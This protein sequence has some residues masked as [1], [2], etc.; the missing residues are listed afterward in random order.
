MCVA[1]N[2]H[3]ISCRAAVGDTPRGL[4]ERA[5]LPGDEGRSRMKPWVPLGRAPIPGT[6]RHGKPDEL[7]LWRRG[8]EFSIRI[9]GY[10]SELMNSR[11]HGSEEALATYT[12][13]SVAAREGAH[14]LVGGLGMGF[15]LAAALRCAGPGA[16]VTVAELVP[17][18]VEWNRGPL[19]E[20]AGRPL[21]DPRTRVHVGDVG[22]LLR[23]SPGAFDAVLLDVDNG[24]EGMTS[25][26]NDWLYVPRGLAAIRAALRP[27]G[28]LGVWSVEAVPRFTAA[29]NRAGFS[30]NVRAARAR[31]GRGARHTIWV[32][33]RD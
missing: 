9:G 29:L 4:G 3:S 6:L 16:T 12:C 32:A 5:T 10:V 13:P 1:G 31:G 8:D 28:V 11:Q 20:V 21:G 15:T 19:G 14:V 17:E 23:R 27:G 30:V 25:E 26:D 7:L 24:P 2:L 33:H 22:E 18:V